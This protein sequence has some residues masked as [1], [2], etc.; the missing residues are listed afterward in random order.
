MSKFIA[1]INQSTTS[2]RCILFNHADYCGIAG[3]YGYKREKY[4]ISMQVG[5][6]LFEF[7]HQ[8]DALFLICDNETCRWQITHANKLPAL[9]PVELLSVA[10]GY[11][12]EEPLASILEI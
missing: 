8:S 1:S 6:P 9:H 10:Y 5:A 11:P 2:T 4:V 12:P 3:T 7:I